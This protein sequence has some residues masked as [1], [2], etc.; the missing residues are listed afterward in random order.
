MASQSNAIL[1]A[2]A[3]GAKKEQSSPEVRLAALQALINSL[4]FI[5]QNF[6]RE[7]MILLI[8]RKNEIMLCKLFVNQRRV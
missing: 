7:V 3:E 6:E 1:T 2:V 4:S 8:F 5:K